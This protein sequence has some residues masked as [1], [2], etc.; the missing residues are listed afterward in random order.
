MSTDTKNS[1][2]AVRKEDYI[3]TKEKV[4][5][6]AADLFGGGQ[7]AMLSVIL[8]VFFTDR[9]G[10]EAAIASSIIMLSKIWDAISD[11][12]MGLISENTR[13]S[14]LG[15]RKPYMV[16][17]GLL[18][19]PALALLFA[20]ITSFSSAGKIVWMIVAYIVYC[21]VSTISQVPYMSMSADISLDYNERNKANTVKLIFDIAAAAIF[22]LLPLVLYEML[23][24]GAITEMAFYLTVVFGFG[25]LFGAPLVVAGLK[26]NERVP[27]DKAVKVKFNF[28]QYFEGL[29]V[30]SYLW[31]ILMYVT[32]FLCMDI[33]SALTMYY[34]NY[35]VGSVELFTIFGMTIKM[36][37]AF[38]IAPLMVCAGGGILVAYKLKSKKS[39]QFAYRF[40][41]PVYILGAIL[42]ACYQPSWPPILVPI[43]AGIAGLGFA[44]AQSMPWLIFPDTVDVAELK[45]GYRPTA[46]MSGVMTFGRKFA[47]A[48]GVG[49][50]GWVM[51]GAGYIAPTILEDGS[52]QLMTQPDSLYLAIRIMLGVSVSLLLITGFFA[53]VK[54][55]VTDK[56][57]ERVRYFN[58]INR[59][60][61]ND[62][63][64]T[65][66]LQEKTALLKE[67]T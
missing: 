8:L 45:L 33:V 44:G 59:E 11:P 41:L 34:A 25:I 57:L 50:V 14:K 39:K 19:V 35:I 65:E 16:I 31:H 28:K 9:I 5:Y 46:N 56:K 2:T 32:A 47:T 15:R 43:F 38:I 24:S 21:T 6:G 26:I 40:G 51:S 4:L 23:A 42:M 49:M 13:W 29:K 3:P 30:K 1:A 64:T 22:Y 37:S 52:S 7:A 55:K 67:L 61:K 20:P 66:E 18:I 27:Y 60:G 10:I 17:G 58:D 12:T 54:Y 36:S 62:T 53:S 48:F 63:L